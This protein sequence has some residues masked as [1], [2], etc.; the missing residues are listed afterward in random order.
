MK[1]IE[2]GLKAADPYE[3]IMRNIRIKDD[4]ILIGG[5]RTKLRKVHVIGFGK[6]SLR[7][8]EAL[9][10]ILGDFILGGVIITPDK[11]G[12]LGSIEISKGDH[13]IPGDNTSRSSERLLEY[14][15]NVEEDDLVIIL[16][17]GG[18]SALFEKPLPGL[19][20]RDLAVATDI[21]MRSGADI[22]ELNTVRKHL[23]AV[24]GGRLLRYIKSK[25]IYSLIMSDVIGDP[26]SF[27]AS[28]PTAADE[29]TYKDAIEVLRNRKIW[30]KIPESV[31]RVL[32]KGLNGEV[33]ESIKPGDKILEKV[34]NIIIASNIISLNAM[35]I[36]ARERG[37]NV[38]NLGP[39]IAG[40]ARE[41]GRTMASILKS[42]KNLGKPV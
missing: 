12:R 34:R 22:I 7:M 3:S 16:I 17:S 11:S 40:E 20:L 10:D 8:A 4:E 13:P 9:N 23:S 39:Y 27:I 31:R 42:I 38:V 26:I 5:F 41:V 25:E 1:L 30:D 28:G 14:L 6:S 18:G 33:E 15:S 29:T 24:K 19:A 37:F 21:L 35:E 2:V 36:Y 32:L